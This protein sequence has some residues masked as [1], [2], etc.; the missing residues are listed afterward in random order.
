MSEMQRTA[1]HVIVIGKG[2]LIADMA[3]AD[4]TARYT[5]RQVRVRSPRLDQLR[6]VLA[7][8]GA[9]VV[10]E[11]DGS[12]TVLGLGTDDVGELAFR[13]AVVLHELTPLSASLEE[14]FIESTEG[15]LDDRGDHETAAAGASEC[16]P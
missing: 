8:A 11:P 13:Q 12:L 16:T 4:F 9:T 14:A 15:T 2:R 1:E 10:A 5:Q 6:P 3:T 7:A